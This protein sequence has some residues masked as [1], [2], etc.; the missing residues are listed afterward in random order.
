M[1]H[2][3]IITRIKLFYICQGLVYQC[4]CDENLADENKINNSNDDDED[5]Q[6]DIYDC[7]KND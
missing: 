6:G 5:D 2:S 4:S 7:D 1:P 3:F